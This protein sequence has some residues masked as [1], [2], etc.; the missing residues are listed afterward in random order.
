MKILHL[1]VIRL[2][3]PINYKLKINLSTNKYKP[4]LLLPNI[5]E[6]NEAIWI[7]I[8]IFICKTLTINTLI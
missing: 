7:I 6:K 2:S 4:Y 5:H 1:V 8:I 3:L